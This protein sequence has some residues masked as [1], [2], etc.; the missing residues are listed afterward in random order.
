MKFERK[1]S[2]VHLD[3]APL[4]DVVLNLLLFF[5]LT[6]H[7]VEEPAIK[8]RLPDSRTAEWMRNLTN[9]NHYKEW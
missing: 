3:I 6:S 5:M 4:V 9:D 2:H 1:R 7:L 8:I